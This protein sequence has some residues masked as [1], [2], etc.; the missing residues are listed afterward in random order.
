MG[1]G[2]SYFCPRTLLPLPHDIEWY[3]NLLL[4]RLARWRQQS[5]GR[6]GDNTICANRFLNHIIPYFVEVIIQDGI[7]FTQ[8]FPNHPLAHMLYVQPV[9]VLID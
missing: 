9:V 1:N 3:E 5:A 6:G 7:F 8:D 2:L 4:P